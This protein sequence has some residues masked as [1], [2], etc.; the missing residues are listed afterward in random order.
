MKSIRLYTTIFLALLFVVSGKAQQSGRDSLNMVSGVVY[1]AATGSVLDGVSVQA[2]NNSRYSTMTTDNGKFTIRVPKKTGMLYV[3]SP[4]YN[5]QRVTIKQSDKL[6]AVYMNSDKFI[7]KQHSE[8]T[9]AATNSMAD[10][11]GAALTVET[12]IENSLNA[13]VRTVTRSNT[14]AIGGLMFIRGINSLYSSTQPLVILD[15]VMMDMQDNATSMHNGA[16]NNIL[17]T[18][19]P[20]DI[21]KVTVIKNATTL[22][23]SKGANGVILI[24]TKR[25]KSMA[26]R[27]DAQIYGGMT[28]EPS[29]LPVM[30]SS[31]Y[32]LYLTDLMGTVSDL[33]QT[34]FHFLNDTPYMTDGKITNPYYWT[35]HNNTNWAD[36]V[37]RTAYT[38]NYKINVQGGDDVA[39]YY[40]SLGYTNAESTIKNND[41]SRLNIRFNTDVKILPNF[42]TRFD[43]SYA[44]STRDLRD[45]G[46]PEDLKSS[47]ISSPAFLSLIKSPFLSPY[48]QDANGN[49][50]KTLSSA[51]DFFS[52]IGT[53]N[54]LGNLVSILTNGEGNNKNN[55][56]SNQFNVSVH[57]ELQL[58]RN[59]VL[60]EL[61]S[62][63]LT[64]MSQRYF[65]PQTGMPEYTISETGVSTNLAKSSFSKETE[66]YS[67]LRLEWNAKRD[68]NKL[69][70]FGGMR[71]CSFN[72]DDNSLSGNNTGND[73]TPDVSYSL[74]YRSM[75]G[76]E[77]PT[78]N[79]A[80]YLNGD[81]SYADRYFAQA[82]LT[83]ETSSNFGVNASEGFKFL[84][85]R[86]ALFPSIQFGWMVS[87]EPWMKNLV[88][89]DELMLTAGYDE[90]GN[91]R[92]NTLASRAY[93]TSVKYLNTATGLQLSNIGN[94]AIQWETSRKWNLGLRSSLLNN[95]LN[96]NF[97]VYHSQTSNLLT[98]K[99]LDNVAGLESYWCNDGALSNSGFEAEI[100]G[101]IL[102]HKNWK[103]EV[104]LSIG[105]YRNEV[106]KLA[107]TDGTLTVD[108]KQVKG[109]T[110]SVYGSDNVAT[111]IGH[112]V[113]VF[114]GYK[115]AGV[116]STDAEAKAAGKNGTYLYQYSS[117]NAIQQFK[118][119]DVHFVDINGD[120]IINS[121]DKTII[122]NPNPDLYGN[123]HAML[124]YKNLSMNIVFNYSLGN[125]VY[126]YQRSILESGSGFYN[127][128]T[129]LCNRWQTEGQVTDIPKVT[130]D[131]PM[132]NSR[133]SDRWIENGSYLRLASLKLSYTVPVSLE[134]LQGMTIW[135]EGENL[136]TL[137]N[138]LGSDPESSAGN[139]VLYQGID[140]G[141][142]QKSASFTFGVKI[143][144]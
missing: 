109:F 107:N 79:L 2:F 135:C 119:G 129:A 140:T 73:K 106:T 117:T 74:K 63:A 31:Q 71:F 40:L 7:D 91:D 138:Y 141:M 88:G 144:L 23:G 94:D 59:L 96:V 125:D 131:D 61:F 89:I 92:I 115:T 25:S 120:G 52:E 121:K 21:E 77:S 126:N 118:A 9:L 111:I 84:K 5:T 27:I 57:P 86:W 33:K 14:P 56:T 143:N 127:Q 12:N 108:N 69:K 113:G 64:R 101:I 110:T 62:Y 76:E 51:D 83:A 41:F 46:V 93:F 18:I 36:Y 55:V 6:I 72:F 102:N 26:T 114:Y 58:N 29:T 48:V 132:G 34:S 122:G 60:S 54:S 65:R 17:S 104:G 116:F 1:D 82:A 30:N 43:V 49:Y 68:I 136:F 139:Q 66:L 39:M 67:D 81:Y 75:I 123:M 44:H 100:N 45:D 133:F 24:D 70:I 105:H 28:L 142:L 35:Y 87:A 137:T 37:Y 134:W 15:G 11:N 130:Y 90:T 98:T 80:Y 103:S 22:Y 8:I 13:D 85:V 4:G 53:N 47:P 112:P 124:S 95:R 42:K 16:Y 19:D 97:N 78:K 10:H 50:T 32:R 99:T 3:K 20:T 128:S 38:Q